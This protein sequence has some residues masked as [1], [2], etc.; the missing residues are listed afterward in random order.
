MTVASSIQTGA[1]IVKIA[2]SGIAI[3]VQSGGYS[4]IGSMSEI[5]LAES[6]KT[7][8][9][10]ADEIGARRQELLAN[11]PMERAA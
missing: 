3:A 5:D 2:C 11:V 1:H 6:E 8:R 7:L 10:L 9:E 4:K